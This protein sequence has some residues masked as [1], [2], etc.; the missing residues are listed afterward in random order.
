MTPNPNAAQNQP[1]SQSTTTTSDSASDPGAD[2]N[3]NAGATR[4]GIVRQYQ[5]TDDPSMGTVKHVQHM[6]LGMF[7]DILPSELLLE[8]DDMEE[9]E[10]TSAVVE[11]GG[12]EAV[13]ELMWRQEAI[14]PAQ[15]ISLATDSKFGTEDLDDLS[16][17]E[18]SALHERAQETLGDDAQGFLNALDVGISLSPNEMAAQAE[19]MQEGQETRPGGREEPKTE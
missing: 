7:K 16:V 6:Q 15:T 1:Q 17:Q 4:E 13:Q 3:G 9:G 19:Q 8:M 14:E 12:F 5:W 11:H 18:M 10:I 2:A